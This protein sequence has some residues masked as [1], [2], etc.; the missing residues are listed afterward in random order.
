VVTG[1]LYVEP[2][3]P[4]MHEVAGTTAEPLVDLPFEALCPGAEAL[5]RLQQEMT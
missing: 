4:D 2:T 1:L 5:D 3:A